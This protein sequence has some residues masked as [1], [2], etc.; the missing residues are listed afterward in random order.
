MLVC[1]GLYSFIEC[2]KKNEAVQHI[3]ILVCG[4]DFC[5]WLTM[6]S[7]S[8]VLACTVS[9]W[10]RVS[11]QPQQAEHRRVLWVTEGL[12]VSRAQPSFVQ[13]II[14]TFLWVLCVETVQVQSYVWA[15]IES[16][17]NS[18][19]HKG[20][21]LQRVQVIFF[22]FLYYWNLNL[23]STA[24]AYWSMNLLRTFHELSK[25]LGPKH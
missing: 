11:L 17:I 16:L 18:T 22:F 6:F 24:N 3:I 13:I 20:W 8:F 1:L 4:A 23:A 5:S 2:S 7:I 25:D 15:H 14:H 19:Q 21:G 10:R 9:G 12:W